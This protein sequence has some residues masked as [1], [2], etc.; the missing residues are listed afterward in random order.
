MATQIVPIDPTLPW[1]E[2]SVQLDNETFTFEFRWNGRAGM[3]FLSISDS[4]GNL[5]NVRVALGP[6]LLYRYR[7]DRLP[8]GVL[9]AIDTSG[10]DQD[11]LADDLGSRVKLAYI[12]A[13]DLA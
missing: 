10:Q 13:A 9:I 1:Q 6:P 8:R 3:W 4:T 7:D 2:F 5:A 11:A 12:P